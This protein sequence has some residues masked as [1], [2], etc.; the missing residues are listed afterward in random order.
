[1]RTTVI[2]PN[3]LLHDAMAL[4]HAATKKEAIIT[5]LKFLV[6][7]GK[8]SDLKRLFGTI[9]VEDRTEEMNALEVAEMKALYK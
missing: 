1:M 9:D 8:S 2:I 7:H 5:A 4:T 3:D 6:Q